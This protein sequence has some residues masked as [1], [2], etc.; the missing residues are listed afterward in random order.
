MICLRFQVNGARLN[1]RYYILY[2]I[3][4]SSHP[5]VIKIN[6]CNRALRSP[7]AV[8]LATGG[9]E[10]LVRVLRRDT[11]GA[12]VLSS[13]SAGQK[14]PMGNPLVN[15]KIAGIMM[16]NS[17]MFTQKPTTNGNMNFWV[18]TAL[19]HNH[20]DDSMWVFRMSPAI[21]GLLPSC[22]GRDSCD[23]RIVHS[24][25]I[26]LGG[27]SPSTRITQKFMSNTGNGFFEVQN[28][29]PGHQKR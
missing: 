14:M 1:S 29:T 22:Q 24:E 15:I 5:K 9:F 25:E 19:I 21:W 17:W 2:T 28:H 10:A 18:F 16:I 27:F 13:G 3:Y 26:D 23:G 4:W 6:T 11:R 8:D 12:A 20:L 7:D